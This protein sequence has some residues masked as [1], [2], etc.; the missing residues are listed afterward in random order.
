L[1]IEKDK[2]TENWDPLNFLGR[3]IGTENI[4]NSAKSKEDEFEIKR[5]DWDSSFFGADIFKIGFIPDGFRFLKKEVDQRIPGNSKRW[6][7]FA[8]IPSEATSTF[9][10]LAEAG[11]SLVETRLTYYHRLNHLPDPTRSCKEATAEDV[12]HLRRTASE[13]VNPFD[14]YHADPF[15]K[16]T[17]VRRY[18]ETY[19]E[20]CIH[21]FAE[22]VFIPDLD[23]PPASFA[24]VSK[25]SHSLPVY[26][27]P[28]TAC[29]PENQGWHFDLCLHALHYA[30]SKESKVLVMTTQSTNKAVIHN[31]EKLG[32]KYGSCTHLFTKS[33]NL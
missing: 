25:V 27:I 24:A 6:H 29:L 9:P 18:L 8:E 30:K 14:K 20:N 15:F 5:I 21:G 1:P 16:D 31:C 12:P 23:P 26:R 22:K 28:L 7:I 2:M 13:A 3:V 19:I 11:F 32:F 17:E 4:K 33:S 10:T